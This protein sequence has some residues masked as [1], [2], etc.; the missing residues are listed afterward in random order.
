[1]YDTILVPTDGSEEVSAA[2]DQAFELAST[3]DAT[4]HALYVVDDSRGD[5]GLMGLDNRGPLAPL[6]EEGQK[7]VDDVAQKAR[8]ANVAVT[9][10]VRQNIPHEG[11]R[12][13]ADEHDVDLIIMSSQGR[14]GVSRVL[15]GSVTERVLRLTDRPVLVVSKGAPRHDTESAE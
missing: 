1:M 4:V 9:T 10:T 12:A 15:F 13:Y 3:Y 14:S 2:L 7:A 6:R 11:I 8:D 5:S